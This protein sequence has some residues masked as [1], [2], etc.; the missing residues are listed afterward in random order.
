MPHFQSPLSTIRVPGEQTCPSPEPSSLSLKIPCRRTPQ[1]WELSAVLSLSP[2][3]RAPLHVP[4]QGSYGKESFISR[5]NGLFINSFISVRV[6]NKQPSH[7]NGEN[8]WSPSTQP[9]VDGRP[10]YNGVQPGS[11]KESLT[12]LIT[13]PQCLAAL[14]TIPSTLACVDQSPVTQLM[15]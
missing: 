11:P 12:T 8:I 10:T 5:A 7:E 9:H 3:Q 6:P 1:A 2:W 13:L 4:Q 15:S 14:G